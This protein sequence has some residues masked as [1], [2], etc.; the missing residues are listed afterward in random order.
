MD[1]FNLYRRSL[2]GHP[3]YKWLDLHALA[4][5]LMPDHVVVHVDYF[6]AHL[7]PGLQVDPQTHVRQ[8]MYLRALASCKD[9]ITTRFGSF[10][11]DPR[12]MPIHPLVIDPETRQWTTTR[13]RKLEEKGSDVNLASRMTAD[14]FRGKASIFVLVSNDSDQ[15]GPMEMLKHELG[16]STGII[17]PMESS[18]GSKALTKTQPDFISHVTPSALAASQFP[19]VMTDTIGTFH[20]PLAWS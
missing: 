2:S 1:G 9:R 16:F 7:R 15:V 4:S 11:S 17:F 10:R 18:R 6:T 5:Y 13:V 8:Q 19:S 20:R 12:N 3:E 14:A